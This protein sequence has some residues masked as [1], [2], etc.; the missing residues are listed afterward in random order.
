MLLRVTKGRGGI[1]RRKREGM[2][3]NV[4]SFES[5]RAVIRNDS[6]SKFTIVR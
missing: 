3:R 5:L 4:L 6:R 1:G 2:D